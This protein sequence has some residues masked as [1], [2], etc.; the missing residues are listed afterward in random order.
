MK[1]AE[2]VARIVSPPGCAD[3]PQR[4]GP[5]SWFSCGIHLG[6]RPSRL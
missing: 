3:V 4:D 5:P 2:N 6:L 1:Y